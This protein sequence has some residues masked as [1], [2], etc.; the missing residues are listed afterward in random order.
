MT[1]LSVRL[2]ND[3]HKQLSDLSNE[4]DLTLNGEIIRLLRLALDTKLTDGFRDF[5]LLPPEGRIEVLMHAVGTHITRE[6]PDP[7]G[8][9][10]EEVGDGPEG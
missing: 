3:L 4:S 8:E 6:V 7:L 5:W 9:T 10:E 1:R 2:P